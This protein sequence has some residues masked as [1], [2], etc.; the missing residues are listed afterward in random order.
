MPAHCTSMVIAIA[1]EGSASSCTK[2]GPEQ[3][4]VDGASWWIS[5]H[6]CSCD[7][8]VAEP[9]ADAGWIWKSWSQC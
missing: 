2:D 4:N 6:G 1:A 9:A 8:N 5:V 7:H 3:A